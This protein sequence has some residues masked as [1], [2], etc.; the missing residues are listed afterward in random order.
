MTIP[1]GIVIDFENERWFIIEVELAKHDIWKHVTPQLVK[2]LVALQ[3]DKNRQS[4]CK[5]A[6]ARLKTAPDLVK[7]MRD[8]YK[9]TDLEIAE[10]LHGILERQPQID[11]PI[12]STGNEDS[13]SLCLCLKYDVNACI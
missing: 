8:A 7:A 2:F 13:R 5:I 10:S 1:D 4:S 3:N 6:L 11:I 12:D 9:M